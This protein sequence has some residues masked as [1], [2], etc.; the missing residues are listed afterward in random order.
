MSSWNDGPIVTFTAG[1]DLTEHALVMGEAGSSV[2]PAE[3]IETTG[4]QNGDRTVLGTVVGGP[5]GPG[6]VSDGDAVSVRMLGCVATSKMIAAKALT[7]F[8]PVFSADDGQVTDATTSETCI[9]VTIAAAADQG[10]IIEVAI[11]PQPY[12]AVDAT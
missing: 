7:V 12:D 9:G 2:I 11:L 10:D 6:D 4:G 8:E 5:D 3:V 1:E